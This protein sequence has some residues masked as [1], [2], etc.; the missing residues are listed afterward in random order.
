MTAMQRR[1]FLAGVFS[2]LAAPAIVRAASLM[3]VKVLDSEWPITLDGLSLYVD[4][5]YPG[6]S[7]EMLTL[8]TRRIEAAEEI[9][10]ITYSG[11]ANKMLYGDAA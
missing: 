1:V 10:R 4:I 3:P 7:P 8:L 2:A 6:L 11:W 5:P 9:F